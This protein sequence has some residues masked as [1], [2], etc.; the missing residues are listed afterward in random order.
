MFYVDTM[1]IPNVQYENGKKFLHLLYIKELYGCMESTLL[2]YD[3]W[4]WIFN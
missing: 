4:G 1:H 3:K 2:C